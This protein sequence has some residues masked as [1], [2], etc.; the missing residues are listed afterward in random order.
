[1][2]GS[3]QEKKEEAR[4]IVIGGGIGGLTTAIAFCRN[5]WDVSV[6]EATPDLR[7]IGKGIWVPINAMHVLGRLGLAEVGPSSP[8]RGP[9]RHL[10]SG[11]IFVSAGLPGRRCEVNMSV[12]FRIVAY[13]ARCVSAT[14]REMNFIVDISSL[15]IVH[16][17]ITNESLSKTRHQSSIYSAGLPLEF[18][19]LS[20]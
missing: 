19:V 7:P 16:V 12:Y 6:H 2:S 11:G 1:M 14:V 10:A 8:R 17:Q 13:D 3:W 9:D 20:C 15:Y 5:G 18:R 4:V